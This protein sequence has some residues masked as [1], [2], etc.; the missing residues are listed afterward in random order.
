[1]CYIVVEVSSMKT[2]LVCLLLLTGCTTAVTEPSSTPTPTAET[3]N[4]QEEFALHFPEES[5][6]ALAEGDEESSFEIAILS[7]MPTGYSNHLHVMDEDGLFQS[8]VIG[9]ACYYEEED[10]F[11][12]DGNTISFTLREENDA[13]KW[14]YYAT[15]IEVIKD[16]QGVHWKNI[17][18]KIK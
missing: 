3:I 6:V 16:E 5:I 13:G 17:Q 10:G 1:M 7:Q 15:T 2:P 11:T 9:D 12:V 4:V 18:K 8:I 14:D